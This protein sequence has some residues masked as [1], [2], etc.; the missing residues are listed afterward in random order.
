MN[1]VY[2][3]L[4]VIGIGSLLLVSCNDDEYGPRKE[5][6]PVI[7]SAS[8][9]PSG[10]VFGDSVMLTAKITDPASNLSGLA[11]EIVADDRI[12]TSG[13]I[14]IGGQ[15]H[16]VAQSIYVPL[17]HSLADNVEVKMNLIARNVLKGTSTY[18]VT[19]LTGKRPV[20]SQLYLVTDHG[21]VVTLT[22]QSGNKNQFYADGLTFDTSFRYRIAEKLNADKTIDYSGHVYGNVDGKLGL[23]SE[24]G[25]SAFIY[26][27]DGDYTKELL[28]DAFSL[29]AVSTGSKL[30]EDDL[31]LGNFSSK[32]AGGEMF[33]VLNTHLVNGN[34]YSLFGE[35]SQV[36]N[37]YNPDFFDRTAD[38]KVTFLGETGDYTIYYN[39]VRKNVFVGVDNPS[40]PNYLLMCGWGLGY[41]TNVSSEQINSVYSGKGRT[42][43]SWGFGDVLSYVL[44]RKVKDN[45]FQGTFYT[46][47]DHDHYAGFKPFENTGWGNE[48]K[49]G[50]F[51]FTGEQIIQGK[52]N[53]EIPNVEG[54]PVIESANYRFTIDL[55]T[56][57]VNIEKVIL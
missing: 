57:T 15:L 13:E 19:G 25:E 52:E 37:I 21:S 8:V 10:V 36:D 32:D 17:L 29:D 26:S 12:L 40:Y 16:E 35:L 34:S 9:T 1:L 42:H 30:G 2:K 44:L 20:Y 4:L 41:P 55:N 24:S 46:P 45:V 50:S 5:S 14:P 28:F 48:K 22:P 11:Y 43:T 23:I 31:S 39:P 51:V 7:E 33:R 38:N 53:W 56:H 6:T 3:I 54:A 47:G 49:A 18:Q 27:T